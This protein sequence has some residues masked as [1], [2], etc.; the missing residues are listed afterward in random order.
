MP[1]YEF[2][3]CYIFT[4]STFIFSDTF[5]WLR[6]L[7]LSLF[8][9][10]PITFIL[11]VISVFNLSFP[12]IKV[13]L[14]LKCLT[15]SVYCPLMFIL[16][17]LFSVFIISYLFLIHLFSYWLSTVLPSIC[18]NSGVHFIYYLLHAVSLAF[19]A[20]KL[21]LHS[22]VSSILIYSF[23]FFFRLFLLPHISHI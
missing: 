14:P 7:F 12:S 21:I 19:Q 3:N 13:H 22:V 4:T 15:C 18:P 2:W 16:C 23:S 1:T 9:S 6:N 8:N 17:C 10:L 5:L 11:S 20:I